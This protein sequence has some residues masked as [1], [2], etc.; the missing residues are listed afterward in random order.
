MRD[1]LP[2]GADVVNESGGPTVL[3][4]SWTVLDVDSMI[5]VVDYGWLENEGPCPNL[6]CSVPECSRER[7]ARGDTRG[8]TDVIIVVTFR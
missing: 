6:I 8:S 3:V 4:V 7:G 2:S 5:D 1:V